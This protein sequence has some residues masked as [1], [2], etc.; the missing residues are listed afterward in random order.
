M[1]CQRKSITQFRIES[2]QSTMAK[3]SS[4]NWMFNFDFN[5][6]SF[7]DMVYVFV[8]DPSPSG[9][10]SYRILS[11]MLFHFLVD[12]EMYNST[13]VPLYSVRMCASL[14]GQK[15]LFSISIMKMKVRIV[16]KYLIK[17]DQFEAVLWHACCIYIPISINTLRTNTIGTPLIANCIE[18]IVNVV[19]FFFFFSYKKFGMFTQCDV[20]KHICP[21]HS[22]TVPKNV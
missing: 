16:H 10:K 22:M 20:F 12:R 15:S 17:S 14:D 2:Q 9:M 21:C 4:F 6:V 19:S 18:W 11:E 1:T 3:S 7:L 5:F 8:V 13:Y